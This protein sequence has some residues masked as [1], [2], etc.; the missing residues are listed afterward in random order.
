MSDV[1]FVDDG[2]ERRWRRCV[3][4]DC[5]HAGTHMP[6][7][8]FNALDAG[9]PLLCEDCFESWA[10]ERAIEQDPAWIERWAA[11]ENAPRSARVYELRG[12][13]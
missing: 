5:G 3:C 1:L 11:G 6:G 8:E 12:A 9:G 2:T 7:A 13:S 10:W 4:G